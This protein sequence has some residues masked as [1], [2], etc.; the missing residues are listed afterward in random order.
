M[1]LFPGEQVTVEVESVP[2][3]CAFLL[4]VNGA[5]TDYKPLALLSYAS[6]AGRIGFTLAP[7]YLTVIVKKKTFSKQRK[8]T[9]CTRA[10]LL[11]S[12]LQMLTDSDFVRGMQQLGLE[13]LPY[14]LEFRL[15]TQRLSNLPLFEDKTPKRKRRGR[16]DEIDAKRQ[17]LFNTPLTAGCEQVVRSH[18]VYPDESSLLARIRYLENS[19]RDHELSSLNPANPCVR[20]ECAKATATVAKVRKE[21][22]AETTK[23]DLRDDSITTLKSDA[24]TF[25]KNHGTWCIAKSDMI[26]LKKQAG[27]GTDMAATKTKVVR[28]EAELEASITRATDLETRLAVVQA[29]LD[30]A[31]S[32][33]GTMSQALAAEKATAAAEKFT[34][35]AAAVAAASANTMISKDMLTHLSTQT[36]QFGMKLIGEMF[37]GS[38][39]N[40]A[41][42]IEALSTKASNEAA[43]A[44]TSGSISKADMEFMMKCMHEAA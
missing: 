36:G 40:T 30:L 14:L 37:T 19:V 1:L 42:A 44:A 15:G 41:A 5:V 24:R 34:A 10:T 16:E 32:E 28:L 2:T 29:S 23:V 35:Q 38:Q 3:V 21:L 18:D 31:R 12:P 11:S 4:A 33:A 13:E 17:R 6:S 9:T 20:P 43:T 8:R 27:A 7:L 26:T 25:K 22:I 39:A